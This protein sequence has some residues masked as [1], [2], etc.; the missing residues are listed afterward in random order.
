MDSKVFEWVATIN[1]AY[2]IG[3][4][5]YIKT[6]QEGGE[7]GIV[8]AILFRQTEATY[9]VRRDDHISYHYDIE[10]STDKPIE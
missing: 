9:E 7:K 1:P 2:N 5:V 8:T 10:L 4:I 6:A 3:D